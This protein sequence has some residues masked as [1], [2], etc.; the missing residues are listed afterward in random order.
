MSQS[1]SQCPTLRAEISRLHTE[2]NGLQRRVAYLEDRLSELR[3][4]VAA[5]VA[6]IDADLEQPTMSRHRLVLGVRAQLDNAL[7]AV[8]RRR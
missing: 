8:N 6:A 7:D 3:G 4:A 1:C 2:V 5:T